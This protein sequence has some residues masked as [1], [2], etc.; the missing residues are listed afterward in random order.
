[1]S[2]WADHDIE[3]KVVEV[4]RE[5]PHNNEQHAFGRPFM[6]AYQLAIELDR[7]YPEVRQALARPLG[8][9]GVG[10]HNSLAQYLGQQLST[11]IRDGGID[12]PV[13]GRFVSNMNVES[14]R[15]RSHDG[16][17]IVSSLTGTPYDLSMFRLNPVGA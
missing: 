6:T 5:V 10:E 9:S 17:Q 14:I 16:S 13:E 2:T 8:G 15:Y 12:Y 4:L 11:R 3:T 1:M 7:R